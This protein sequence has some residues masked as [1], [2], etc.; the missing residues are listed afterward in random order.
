MSRLKSVEVLD[1]P[2]DSEVLCA[3]ELVQVL[4]IDHDVAVKGGR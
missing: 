3:F 2:V 1:N 4:V